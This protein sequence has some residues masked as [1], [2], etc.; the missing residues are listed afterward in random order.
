M[1]YLISV[2]DRDLSNPVP[3][4]CLIVE[5]EAPS[6]IW[7]DVTV[8]GLTPGS[9]NTVHIDTQAKHKT[10]QWNRIPRTEHTQH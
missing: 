8:I 7:Y 2:N 9:T 3:L 1:L 10:I 6:M 4:D 5:I